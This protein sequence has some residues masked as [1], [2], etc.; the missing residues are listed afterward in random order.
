MFNWLDHLEE[1]VKKGL[2]L[3]YYRQKRGY[4]LSWIPSKDRDSDGE[5][6]V[7]QGASGLYGDKKMFKHFGPAWDWL[8]DGTPPAHK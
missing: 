3:H 7:I 8:F 6:Q 5:F 4:Y 1:Q 2:I